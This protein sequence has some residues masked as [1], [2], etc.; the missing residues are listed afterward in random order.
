MRARARALFFCIYCNILNMLVLK[1]SLQSISIPRS[2]TDDVERQLLPFIFRQ[3]FIFAHVPRNI[4]WNLLGFATILL[5]WNQY[6]AFSISSSSLYIT[7][8]SSYAY[9]VLSS[10]KLV[11][12][13]LFMKKKKLFIN[14]LNNKGPKTDPWG[15]AEVISP[16]CTV[17]WS[18]FTAL[19]S[20]WKIT[21]NKL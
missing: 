4:N 7:K 16:P 1:V 2:D 6:E 14:M 15:T 10:A 9:N 12:G 8:L 5:I 11:V 19:F 21:M 13:D 17:R 18:Y 3:S 20:I